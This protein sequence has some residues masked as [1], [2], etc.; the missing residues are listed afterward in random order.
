MRY[1]PVPEPGRE[2]FGPGSENKF[3]NNFYDFNEKPGM[4]NRVKKPAGPNLIDTPDWLKELAGHGYGKEWMRS[5][6][7]KAGQPLGAQAAIQ[8]RQLGETSFLSGASGSGFA[9]EGQRQIDLARGK[10]LADLDIAI[11]SN[12]ESMKRQA[13]QQLQAIEYQNKRMKEQWKNWSE[14]RKLLEQQRAWQLEYSNKQ[15]Q[16]QEPLPWYEQMLYGG[17]KI[18]ASLLPFALG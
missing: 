15:L 10:A 8:K 9:I 3:E 17:L 13:K 2:E 16:T 12:N 4:S 5:S 6:F 14:Q 7:L 1:F 11:E 18:G